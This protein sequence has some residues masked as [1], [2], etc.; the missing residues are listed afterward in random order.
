M[1]GV[2]VDLVAA[3]DE[4]LQAYTVGAAYAIGAEERSGKVAPGYDADLVV[5]SHDPTVSLDGLA[6]VATMKAGRFT[7]GADALEG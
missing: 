2:R 3:P 1:L 4:V 7:H 5:L 6:A